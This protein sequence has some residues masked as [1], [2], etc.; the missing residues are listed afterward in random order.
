MNKL[1]ILKR[2]KAL[3]IEKA[4]RSN[5]SIV[6]GD[7]AKHELFQDKGYINQDKVDFDL[8][9][10]NNGYL[11][12]GKRVSKDLFFEFIGMAGYKDQFHEVKFNN[13]SLD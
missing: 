6:D 7:G 11:V 13:N 3:R 8:I 10:G 5:Y 2:L 4:K 1:E 9:F 12:N